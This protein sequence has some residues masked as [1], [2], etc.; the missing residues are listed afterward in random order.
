MKA[1]RKENKVT[2][3][4]EP[5]RPYIILVGRS[6]QNSACKQ[7]Y[8]SPFEAQFVIAPRLCGMYIQ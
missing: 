6:P 7:V 1:A 4:Q 3:V 5:L 8:L 2:K